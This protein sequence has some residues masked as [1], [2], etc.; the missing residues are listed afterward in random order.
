MQKPID[1]EIARLAEG[2]HGVFAAVHLALIGVKSHDRKY[3]VTNGRWIELH[4]GVYRVAGV[5]GSWRSDL[6][7]AC[8][9]G[10]TRAVASHRSAAELHGLPGRSSSLIEIT[11]HHWH[12]TR[13][14]GLV[15]HESRALSDRDITIIDAIP[16]TTVERTIFDL[17]AVRGRKTVDLA[18]DNALRRDLTTFDRLAAASR[19]L[20]RRGLEGTRTLRSLLAE[21]DPQYTPTASEQEQLLLDVLRRCNFPEPVRQFEIRD[22]FGVFVGRVDLAYPDLMIVI[23]YDSYQEHVGNQQHVRDRRRQSAIGAMGYT[24]I[25]ATAEDV[26]YGQGAALAS[27]LRRSI[28]RARR[29]RA[30]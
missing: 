12:R 20:G 29:L 9:A 11:C 6:L 7:A 5:P 28:A 21:R 10:G 22:E 16:V 14:D 24:I 8:W 17:C 13:H 15:V 30:T 2:Q 4:R 19:R 25:V 23:E 18:I 26:R 3:R 1:V 27:S